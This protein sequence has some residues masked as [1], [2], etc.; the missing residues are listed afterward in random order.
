MAVSD[1]GTVTFGEAPEAPEVRTAVSRAGEFLQDI[2][3]DGPVP[4]EEV[5]RRGKTEDISQQSLYRAKAKLSISSP[6]L[7][8]VWHWALP[9]WEASANSE[10]RRGSEWDDV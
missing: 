10:R 1:D 6:K 2:L 4:S 7:R 8:G 9:N 5:L 3:R